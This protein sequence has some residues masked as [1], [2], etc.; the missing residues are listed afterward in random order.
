M[1]GYVQRTDFRISYEGSC[2]SLK[3]ERTVTLLS[4]IQR[5]ACALISGP[6]SEMHAP[7]TALL[8]RSTHRFERFDRKFTRLIRSHGRTAV[9]ALNG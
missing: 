6:Q 7:G 2:D 4:V 8:F 9:A 3:R 1:T 5:T